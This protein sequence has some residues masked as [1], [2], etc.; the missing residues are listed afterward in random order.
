MYIHLDGFVQTRMTFI[1]SK[2]S[3]MFLDALSHFNVFSECELVTCFIFDFT[4]RTNVVW[5]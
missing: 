3:L 2:L 1:V 5:N 4:L